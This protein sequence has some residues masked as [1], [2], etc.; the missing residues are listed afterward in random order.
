MFFKNVGVTG[1]LLALAAFGAG[2]WRPGRT[3]LGPL[4]RS[5][6]K[7][8]A[9][10]RGAGS[11][12]QSRGCLL[13]CRQFVGRFLVFPLVSFPHR[14][15]RSYLMAHIAVVY[16]SGYGHTQRL[17]QSVAEGAGAQLVAIDAEG[18]PARRRLGNAGRGQCHHFWLAHVHR[19]SFQ[20]GSS[21]SLPT[22]RPSP[23]SARPGRT[24]CSLALPT[25]PAPTATS[26]SRW[27]TCS[28]WP[29]STVASGWATA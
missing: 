1:G 15:N 6:D 8:P 7:G 4:I 20:A 25:A 21:R 24:S 17:A 11:G 2:A 27:T 10:R 18:Q 5:V 12:I 28:T 19:Q 29:C 13:S 22:P 26:R 23:G 16:H 14:F 3:P 9:A